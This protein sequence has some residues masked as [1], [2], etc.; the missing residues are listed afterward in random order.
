VHQQLQTGSFTASGSHRPD[1]HA[2]T[3]GGW[4][5]DEPTFT[6]TCK[7]LTG[8]IMGFSH[9]TPRL[10][11]IRFPDMPK[12]GQSAGP[13]PDSFRTPS[14]CAYVDREDAVAIFHMAWGQLLWRTWRPL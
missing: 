11:D 6:P 4:W 5:Y 8:Q 1:T 12:A 2:D 7:R 3:V 13:S 14:G 10:E 9:L